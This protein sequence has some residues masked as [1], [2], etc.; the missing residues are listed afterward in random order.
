M[1]KIIYTTLAIGILTFTTTTSF[2]I[3]DDLA[4]IL[5]KY[6]SPKFQG[7]WMEYRTLETYF[8]DKYIRPREYIA[9]KELDNDKGG[10][11]MM[12][13]RQDYS[14]N[15]VRNAKVVYTYLVD[16]KRSKKRYLGMTMYDRMGNVNSKHFTDDPTENDDDTFAA[17]PQGH[18]CSSQIYQNLLT[19]GGFLSAQDQAML[20]KVTK[21]A[22][23]HQIQVIPD[24]YIEP[25]KVDIEKYMELID[26]ENLEKEKKGNNCS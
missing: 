5:K 19:Q 11:I 16:C 6:F 12:H 21:E 9:V 2:A 25:P 17:S 23:D 26:Q 7:Q 24:I 10:L 13:I 8:P 15:F 4:N 1:K 14:G 20:D 18:Y 3:S 22:R